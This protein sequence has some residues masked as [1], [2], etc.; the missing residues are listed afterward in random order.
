MTHAS[1]D[2]LRRHDAVAVL[3]EEV[4][5][6]GPALHEVFTVQTQDT[7][8]ATIQH[9]LVGRSLSTVV[10]SLVAAFFVRLQVFGN[11]QNGHGHGFLSN[12]ADT[13]LD[14]ISIEQGGYPK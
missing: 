13:F 4:Q 5:Q 11:K 12:G 14:R 9:G 1:V 8:D 6:L 3:V 7:V 10:S 2:L